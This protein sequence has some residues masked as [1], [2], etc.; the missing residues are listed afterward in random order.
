MTLPLRMATGI[1]AAAAVTG[2]ISFAFQAFQGCIQGY[3]FI[4][5]A[6]NIDKDGDLIRARL[7]FEQIRL[8]AW[9]ERVG[10]DGPSQDN[11]RLH[12]EFINQLLI[13]ERDLLTSAEKLK[14]HYGLDVREETVDTDFPETDSTDGPGSPASKGGIEKFLA[15]LRPS[16]GCAQL[17]QKAQSNHGAFRRIAW[18]ALGKDDTIKVVNAIS[19]INYQLEHL[20]DTAESAR[21]RDAL[22]ALLRGVLSLCTQTSEVEMLSQLLRDDNISDPG[23]LVAAAT[24]KNIRLTVGFDKRSDETSVPTSRDT[25]KKV[26][27]LT[28]LNERKISHESERARKGMMLATYNRKPVL[29]E[30]KQ[31]SSSQWAVLDAQMKRLALLLSNAT[32]DS[33]YCLPCNGLLSMEK[34]QCFGLVYSMPGNPAD[35]VSPWATSS[36]YELMALVPRISLSERVRIAQCIAQAMLQLH[37]VGWLHKGICSKSIVFLSPEDSRMTSMIYTA[38]Y[39][40]GYEYARPDTDTAAALTELPSISL[41]DELYRH[42]DSRGLQRKKYEKAFDIYAFGCVLVEMALWTKLKDIHARY[43]EPDWPAK[44]SKAGLDGTAIE[45]PE[46]SELLGSRKFVE[47]ITHSAGDR[48]WD[49]VQLCLS[50]EESTSTDQEA[51]LDVER[52]VLNKLRA[53]KL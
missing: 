5:T 7:L 19:D 20:L 36:L 15:K 25:A 17:V 9:A 51:S 13:Q 49:A 22:D 12:W 3:K 18:A 42:P 8:Q 4:R 44:F 35:Q 47:D 11:R 38:P 46:L 6:Q 43:G 14:Q 52:N 50:V 28:V 16:H 48:Y 10:L 34:E 1:D 29:V 2:L 39:L 31:A 53:C 40:L 30:W 26:P 41:E 45:L 23:S 33:F 32:N 21:T 27:R 37:T 24:L